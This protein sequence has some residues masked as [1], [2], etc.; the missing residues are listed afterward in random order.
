MVKEWI[1][2]DDENEEKA[3]SFKK[4][5]QTE[6]IRRFYGKRFTIIII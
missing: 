1:T 2:S 5:K 3:D 6:H 4:S